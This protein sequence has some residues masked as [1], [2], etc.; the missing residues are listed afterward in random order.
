[1]NWISVKEKLPKPKGVTS[2][3]VLVNDKDL[4]QMVAYLC[5]I[6]G[7]IYWTIK[8][9]RSANSCGELNVTHWMPLPKEPITKGRK[10]V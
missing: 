10:N 2:D 4:G 6:A 3:Y 5:L 7:E 8:E 9:D 1:M